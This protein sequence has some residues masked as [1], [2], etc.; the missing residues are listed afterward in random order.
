MG[1][2]RNNN[3]KNAKKHMLVFAT[4]YYEQSN[5]FASNMIKVMQEEVYKRPKKQFSINIQV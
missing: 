5:E 3:N 4:I 2:Q 1:M